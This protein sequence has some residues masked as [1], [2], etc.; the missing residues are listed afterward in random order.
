MHHTDYLQVS[1]LLVLSVCMSCTATTK[2]VTCHG[3]S[4]LALSGLR[5]R[6]TLLSSSHVHLQSR[7]SSAVYFTHLSRR[8]SR[9]SR[10]KSRGRGVARVVA[11]QHTS[12][13]HSPWQPSAHVPAVSRRRS[14]ILLPLAP[15]G[16]ALILWTQVSSASTA[17]NM[18]WTPLNE[19]TPRQP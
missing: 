15:A 9:R 14:E 2:M 11:C 6:T 16:T 1:S 8:K 7:Q 4:H 19:Q 12:L 18:K 5:S 13:L 3:T 10:I 17:D